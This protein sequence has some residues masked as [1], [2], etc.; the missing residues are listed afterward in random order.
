MVNRAGVGALY[1]NIYDK[2]RRVGGDRPRGRPPARHLTPRLHGKRKTGTKVPVFL[3][4]MTISPPQT[5]CRPRL[6]SEMRHLSVLWGTISLYSEIHR[7]GTQPLSVRSTL[8]RSLAP[9]SFVILQ[10]SSPL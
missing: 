6:V 3:F 4:M 9:P 10:T 2:R 1:A 7:A 5:D 8:Y